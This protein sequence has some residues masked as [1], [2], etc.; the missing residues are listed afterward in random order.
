MKQSFSEFRTK[1]SPQLLHL[2]KKKK[3]K[4]KFFS[5]AVFIALLILLSFRTTIIFLSIPSF[6]ASI[7]QLHCTFATCHQ[8]NSYQRWDAISHR[9]VDSHSHRY[10]SKPHSDQ[11][12]DP[13]QPS[14][15]PPPHASP[16]YSP[17][18]VTFSNTPSA[19]HPRST[20][21]TLHES[22]RSS[23]KPLHLRLPPR[24]PTTNAP[25]SRSQ[26]NPP[27]WAKLNS[28]LPSLSHALSISAD[29]AA[30][31]SSPNAPIPRGSLSYSVPDARIGI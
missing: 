16:P 1:I 8:R 13:N 10:P 28:G 4:K 20:T 21:A 11:H 25:R 17:H 7:T 19:Q 9:A 22:K 15:Q 14:A 3:K 12:C 6:F 26:A 29:I 24:P 30:R 2:R 5:N 27:L 18:L 23:P 31:T